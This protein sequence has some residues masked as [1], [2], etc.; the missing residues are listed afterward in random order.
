M[1]I[2][3]GVVSLGCAKNLVDTEIMLGYLT[4]L[5]YK[6]V[7]DP[8]SADFIIINTCGF[9]ESAKEESIRTIFEMAE[10]KTMGS[11]RGLIVTGCLSKRYAD[12]LLREIPEIDGVLGT[13]ELDQVGEVIA[14]ILR[15][16]RIRKVNNADFNY[17]QEYNRILTT[18]SHLAYLKIAE[19]CNHSCAFCVIPKIRGGYRSRTPAAIMKEARSLASQGV[20]EIAVIAQDTTAYGH[21]LPK[22]AEAS[23]PS[24]LS[25]LASLEFSWI[26]LLYTYPTSLSDEVLGLIQSHEKFVK[27]VDLP[28]QH[29]SSRV[30]RTM[31]RPGDYDSTVKLITKIREMIPGVTIRSSFI[32]G[33]PGETEEDFQQLLS[34]LRKM[35]LDRVGIFK[36]S[37]EEDTSAFNLTQQISEEEKERRYKVAMQLQQEISYQLNQEL[38]GREIDV[39]IDGVSDESDLVLV[40]RHAGQAPDVDGVVYLGQCNVEIG[41]IVKARIVEAHPYDLVGEVVE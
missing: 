30:L 6:L 20:K 34:F 15:G 35:R 10:M 26:R 11:C 2:Q 23:L 19:G 17:D 1:S 32:V 28:L 5:G 31:K 38:V 24:L 39:V 36:Y 29:V 7:S 41:Q 16:E 25:S 14:R 4:D 22:E 27:Y 40:G 9:I 3:I 18:G 21:D 37:Q 8:V 13:N 33:F 12:D